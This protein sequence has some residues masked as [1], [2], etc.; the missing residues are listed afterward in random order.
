MHTALL[1]FCQLS[2][3]TEGFKQC[4]RTGQSAHLETILF[5]YIFVYVIGWCTVVFGIN[6]TSN[7]VRKCKIARGE[8]E[9]YL[10]PNCIASAI[11]PKYHSRPSY[12]R[13]ILHLSY[14]TVVFL[15]L[16]LDALVK[17]GASLDMRT[18]QARLEASLSA[19]D[20]ATVTARASLHAI[21]VAVVGG[22]GSVQ[23][24]NQSV[25]M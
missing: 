9:C 12:H 3:V 22:P 5:S 21:G 24:W 23:V 15:V 19:S 4:W 7:A 18:Q 6:S 2:S 17:L 10:L 13:L 8:A 1:A 11:N 16:L 25:A 20:S 14:I